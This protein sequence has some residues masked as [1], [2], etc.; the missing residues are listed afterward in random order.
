VFLE[1]PVLLLPLYA[2][3]TARTTEIV[4]LHTN[5]MQAKIDNMGKLPFLAD[6]L[7]KTER[8]EK[9]LKGS[10]RKDCGHNFLK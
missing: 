8:S 2:Q 3:K 4:I 5:D 9:G 7:R 6:S 10:E 1:E